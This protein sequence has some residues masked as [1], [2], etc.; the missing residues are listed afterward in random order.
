[1]SQMRE[2]L[3]LRSGWLSV[4]SNRWKIRIFS[5]TTLRSVITYNEIDYMV[6]RDG[7]YA[8]TQRFTT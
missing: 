1:M 2:F 5:A 8:Y 7:E 3:N 4:A 6:N